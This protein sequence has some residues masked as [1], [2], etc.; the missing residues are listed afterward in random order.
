V[1]KFDVRIGS[2][3]LYVWP[4]VA[5]IWRTVDVERTVEGMGLAAEPIDDDEVLGAR[6]VLVRPPGGPPVVVVEPSTEGRLAAALARDDE[7]D[8]GYYA[9]PPGGVEEAARAGHAVIAEGRGP[10]GR[11]TLVTDPARRSSSF[12]VVVVPPGAATIDA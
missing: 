6:G 8:S 10:F 11:S 9:A 2:G 12:F 1:N 5:L 3:D 4:I 7:G